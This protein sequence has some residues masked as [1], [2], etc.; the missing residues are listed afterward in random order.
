MTHECAYINIYIYICTPN[1]K[2]VFLVYNVHER[3]TWTMREL[4]EATQLNF[5]VGVLNAFRFQTAEDFH[6]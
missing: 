1:H 2:T 6:A 5:V 3:M 4:G